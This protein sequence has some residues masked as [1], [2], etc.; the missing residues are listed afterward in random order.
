MHRLMPMG[1]QAQGPVWV[2]ADELLLEHLSNNL[3]DNALASAEAGTSCPPRCSVSVLA[4]APGQ[5]AV[6]VA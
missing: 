4:D 6:L 1:V 2:L 5:R 3:L